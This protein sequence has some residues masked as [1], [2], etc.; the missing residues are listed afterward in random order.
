MP[1]ISTKYELKLILPKYKV[2]QQR[3]SKVGL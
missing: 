2:Q 3:I 1:Q